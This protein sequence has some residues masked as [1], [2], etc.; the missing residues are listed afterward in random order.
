MIGKLQQQRNKNKFDFLMINHF[1]FEMIIHV[2]T[3]YCVRYDYYLPS[4]LEVF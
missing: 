1:S 3:Y 4:N 2:F